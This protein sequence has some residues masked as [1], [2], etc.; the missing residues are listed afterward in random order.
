MRY[1][2]DEAIRITMA[3]CCLYNMLRSLCIGS[4]MYTP[5]DFL[6]QENELTGYIRLGE[7]RQESAASLAQLCHQGGNHH[8]TDARNLR[9]RWT[10]YFNGPGAVPWQEKVVLG[11]N[12]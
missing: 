12:T 1:D 7:W 4:A 5:S 8:A 6:D 11:Q 10:A 9:D 2:P 3:C